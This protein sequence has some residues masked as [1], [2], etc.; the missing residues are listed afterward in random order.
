[1]LEGMGKEPLPQPVVLGKKR[2]LE[3]KV[4]S[5]GHCSFVKMAE[6]EGVGKRRG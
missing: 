5:P 3:Y 6:E 4:P 2:G 1:M